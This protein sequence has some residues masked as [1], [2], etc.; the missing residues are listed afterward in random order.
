MKCVATRRAAGRSGFTLVEILVVLVIIAILIGLM[1]VGIQGALETA[2]SRSCSNNLRQIGF[3]LQSYNAKN[4]HYPAG[5]QSAGPADDGTIH[6]WSAQALLLPHLEQQVI[7]D[8]IDFNLGYKKVAEQNVTTADGVSTP[9]TSLRVPTFLCPSEVRDEQR[10]VDYPLNYGYN[11]G[12]WL[13]YDPATGEGGLGSFSRDSR[14]DSGSFPDGASTTLAFAEVKAFQTYY[15]NAGLAAGAANIDTLPSIQDI[16]AAADPADLRLLMGDG[17]ATAE[18]PGDLKTSGHTEWVDGRV[19][20]T[21]FTTAFAPNARTIPAV[22][23]A[24]TAGTSVDWTNWQE[25]KIDT[26]TD[27]TNDPPTYAAVTARS[28]HGG[29]VNA[30]MMGGAVTWVRDD[31]NIGVWR[32]FSTRAGGELIP[33]DEQF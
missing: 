29:G 33:K 18:P 16:S 5:W 23:A 14:H 27:P 31:I 13:V 12:V 8:L 24:G 22:G 6:G 17:D 11:A 15:R 1:F 32:A 4:N 9:L 19:H 25:G 2:R 28:Y 20:Q 21:G 3:A 7:S 30:L 26:D 10:G